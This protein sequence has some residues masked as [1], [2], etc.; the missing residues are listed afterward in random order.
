MDDRMSE[1]DTVQQA[2]NRLA[3]ELDADVIHFNGPI[4]RPTDQCL[5]SD[6]VTRNRRENA[7]LMLVTMGGDPDAAYRI[8]RCLQTQYER[9]FLYVSGYCKSA[10]TIIALGAHELVMSDHG[11]LGPLDVQMFKKDEI[12]ETQSGL[13]VMNTLTA[14][15][16]DALRAYVDF[17]LHTKG[18]IGGSITLRTASQIATEMT[19][20]LFAPLYSQIDPLHLGEAARAMSIA[21]QY[22]KRLLS[23]GQNIEESALEFILS[24]YPSHGFVIDRNEASMLFKNVRKPKKSE[25]ILEDMLGNQ[26]RRPENNGTI[27]RLPYKFVS[28]EQPLVESEDGQKYSEEV[29]EDNN[30][31]LGDVEG[32]GFGDANEAAREQPEEG[33]GER[34]VITELNAA[35]DVRG[36]RRTSR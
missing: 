9:F 32:S 17:F 27:E 34:D 10:G 20:G 22:G 24:E 16:D 25:K 23:A 5:I 1:T 12:W 36:K 4:L 26:A 29:D 15:K 19:T 3:E 21:S 2:A 14:L 13:T 30:T 7:L 8:A 6:C 33:N 31:K 18:K 35:R 11:E 28:T